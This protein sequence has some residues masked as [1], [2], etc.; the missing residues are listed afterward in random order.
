MKSD[1]KGV[2]YEKK[3]YIFISLY[4]SIIRFHYFK[5]KKNFNH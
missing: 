1:N 4:E 3:M 2:L 5:K